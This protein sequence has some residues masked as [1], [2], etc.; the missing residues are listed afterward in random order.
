MDLCALLTIFSVLES[1]E[2]AFISSGETKVEPR[3]CIE[4]GCIRGKK[5]KG[6]QT[7]NFDAFFGIPYAEPPVGNLRFRVSTN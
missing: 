2:S 1:L 6:Y 4:N 3:V 5:M 7:E